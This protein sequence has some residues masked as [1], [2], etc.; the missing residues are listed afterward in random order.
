KF[1]ERDESLDEQ[2]GRG[3]PLTITEANPFKT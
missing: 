1:H 2:K 3:C